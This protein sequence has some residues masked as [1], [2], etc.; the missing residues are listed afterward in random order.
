MLSSRRDQLFGERDT[1]SRRQL[2]EQLAELANTVRDGLGVG[3]VDP[4][5]FITHREGV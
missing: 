5:V 2:P 1:L 4:S 3:A